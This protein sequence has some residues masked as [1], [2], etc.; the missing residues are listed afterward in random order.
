MFCTGTAVVVSPVGAITH[1]GKA[2][3]YHGGA[4]GPVA[5]RLYSALTD[6]QLEKAPDPRGWIVEVPQGEGRGRRANGAKKGGWR[7]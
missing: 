1:R 4:V 6:L 7:R 3:S 2:V 5:Q